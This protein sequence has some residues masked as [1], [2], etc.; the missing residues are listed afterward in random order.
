MFAIKNFKKNARVIYFCLQF[1]LFFLF[2]LILSAYA[3]PLQPDY[4]LCIDLPIDLAAKQ[5]QWSCK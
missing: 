3:Q 2:M 1:S 5:V 4:I